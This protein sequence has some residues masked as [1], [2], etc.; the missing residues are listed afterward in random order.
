M[1]EILEYMKKE[2][3]MIDEKRER[4]VELWKLAK[5]S[6]GEVDISHKI[7]GLLIYNQVIDEF[8]K[9]IVEYSIIYIKAEIW[10]S[11]FAYKVDFEKNTF[12][13]NIEL[14]KKFSTIEPNRELLLECLCRFNKARNK[15]VHNLFAIN[16]ALK[17]KEDI[18]EHM[19]LADE[20]IGLLIEYDN[21]VC[22]KFV[23]LCGRVDFEIL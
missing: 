9:D 20:I 16:D 11:S 17:L 23:D 15:V 7:G 12:G 1:D 21:C 10:P 5:L 22:E 3:W 19:S 4:K 6:Q 13:R 14:F 18:D 2:K 8:L